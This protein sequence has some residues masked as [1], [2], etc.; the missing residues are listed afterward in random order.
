MF[1]ARSATLATAA[2][3][4]ALCLADAT[5]VVA[6]PKDPSGTYLTEDTRGRIRVEKCAAQPNKICGYV[7]WSKAPSGSD[8]GPRLD[9]KNPDP[10]KIT[11]P[12][13]GHQLMMGLVPKDDTYQ[14]LIY[15]NEDGK[16]YNVTIYLQDDTL[17]VKGCLV[18]FL[19]KTETWTRVDDVIAG[20]LAGP[21]GGAAGPQHDAEFMVKSADPTTGAQAKAAPKPK[22]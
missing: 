19:C 10:N 4:L 14:G 8:G 13:V 12:I 1:S 2:T 18:A 11:R 16:S 5:A 20:Q 22:P 3:A 7:V 21:T 9:R 17:K 6:A 15:N